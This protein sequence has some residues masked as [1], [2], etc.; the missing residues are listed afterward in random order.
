M[1]SE[2]KLVAF[3]MGGVM[4]AADESIPI[5]ALARLSGRSAEEVF[6]SIFA[7]EKKA[8]V[9]T[10]R[11]AWQAHAANIIE[12]LGLAIEEPELRR[13]HCSSHSPDPDVIRIVESVSRS[14]PVTIASNLP[15]PHW[16]WARSSISAA[17]RFEHP[18]LS[19][20]IGLM[21]PSAGFFQSMLDDYGLESDDVFFT[22]DVEAN[23][24]GA[25]AIGIHSYLFTGA[26][27]LIH[28]LRSHGI[29]VQP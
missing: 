19:Y 13:I 21:K 16:Q 27:Q 1:T 22:D 14:T 2:I 25:A 6:A 8:L 17:S 11:I 23:V 4:V 5:N 20:R 7:P 10:G 28:N 15:E 12:E 24:E 18:A 29:E 9:E 26:G 3:D